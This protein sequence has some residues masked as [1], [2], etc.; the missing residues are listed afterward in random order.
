MLRDRRKSNTDVRLE[1]QG[2]HQGQGQ[3]RL[4]A[5]GIRSPHLVSIELLLILL[6]ERLP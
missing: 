5:E 1:Q 6:A 4:Q 2:K 3:V